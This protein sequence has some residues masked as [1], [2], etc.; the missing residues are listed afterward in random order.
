MDALSEANGTFALTLLKKL[1]EDNSNNVFISPLSISSALAMVLVGARGNT[2]AQMCQVRSGGRAA[3]KG[4]SGGGEDVHQ[5]FQK[6]LSKVNRTSTQYFLRTANRLFGEKTYDFLSAFKDSCRVFY[7]AEVEELD[8]VCA[9]EEARKH[10]NT[11][12]AEKTEGEDV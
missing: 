9:S 4:S 7:Q 10:I 3:E 12:V 5:G 6:L 2:A 1:G 8:F 11:W